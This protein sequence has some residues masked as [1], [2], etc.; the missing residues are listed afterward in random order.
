M[1][2]A[3]ARGKRLVFA[4][5]VVG[6]A[7]TLTA[8][9]AL[10]APRRATSAAARQPRA[11]EVCAV[12]DGDRARL[13]AERRRA[14]DGDRDAALALARH[15]LDAARAEGDPRH[16]GRAQA[17]LAPWWTQAA[18][19]D[20]VL[21]LRATVRQSL[22]DFGGARADLDA[23][24]ARRPEDPQARLTR[25]VV[26]TVQG[27]HAAA[28]GDC[29]V[30]GT[31][32]GELWA[33]A[34][35][36]PLAIRDGGTRA[37]YDRLAEL[38]ARATNGAA[39]NADSDPAVA[40]GTTALGELARAL[41]DDVAAEAHLRRA[42][43]LTPGDVYTLA[44]LSDLLLD[45]G[46]AAEAVALLDPHAEPDP[47]RLRLAIAARR[48]GAVGAVAHAQ[49]VRRGLAAAAARGDDTHLRE[50]ARYF[51]DVEPDAAEA[52]A[53]ARGNW[54]LQREAA[55]ARM[56]LEAAAAAG[57]PA[58]AAPVLA[59]LDDARVD[60]AVLARARVRLGPAGSPR[61]TAPA[62]APAA[63]GGTQ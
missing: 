49:I 52:L 43:E 11:D 63:A 45:A 38:L 18:P 9:A 4:A 10:V 22:H 26:A 48:A 44:V 41:G 16:L 7:G 36:A 40:W 21:L 1:T 31:L 46:R 37:A 17:A 27:D 13:L 58:A 60:H 39:T 8:A 19:P 15:H 2:R 51:L 20:D 12:V 5:G 53:A 35:A 6:L 32:A 59:W 25:A 50:R 61:A 55:D 42:L 29:A 14:A 54:A 23:L 57:D 30:V 33:A 56:L 3:S 34:C 28:A 24:I 62:A 47:L